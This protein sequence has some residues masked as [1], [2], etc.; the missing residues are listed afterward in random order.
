MSLVTS[1]LSAVVTGNAVELMCCPGTT[2]HAESIAMVAQES[3]M[4]MPRRAVRAW[5][6]ATESNG[7]TFF[8]F[9]SSID[10]SI[11]TL[12]RSNSVRTSRARFVLNIVMTLPGGRQAPGNRRVFHRGIASGSNCQKLAMTEGRRRARAGTCR[13]F[14]CR[15]AR[16]RADREQSVTQVGR[17]EIAAAA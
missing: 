7:R 4:H 14:A 12:S 13:C 10:E 9:V 15:F 11:D 16:R 8:I 1:P 5:P 3:A 6:G 17:L 2:V